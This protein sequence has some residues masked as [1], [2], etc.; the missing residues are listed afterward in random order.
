MKSLLLFV[1]AASAF[2]ADA[3]RL[4]YSKSFPGSVPAYVCIEVERNG[5]GVYKEAPDDETP[6]KFQLTESETNEAF[7]LAGKLD[8]FKRPLE[9][10]LKVAF[11]GM[12]T[13]R[14]EEGGQKSET[15]FNYSEDPTARAIADWFERVSESEQ[16]FVNL[17]RAAKYDKLGVL[18]ALLQLEA[19]LERKRLMATTQYL[20]LLDRIIRNESYMHAARVRASGIAEIIRGV[21]G[22]P[23]ATATTAAPAK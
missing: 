19:A 13:F 9:S 12:K 23:A 6:L 8:H 22:T 10:N 17:Q 1:V 20:P 15:Q 11:M 14:W 16:Y 4:V 2:A 21:S 18:K 5:A 7:L 3:P